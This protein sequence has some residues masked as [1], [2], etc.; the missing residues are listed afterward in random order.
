MMQKSKDHS[1][2]LKILLNEWNP[3]GI[4][5]PPDEYDCLIY[6]LLNLL[7]QK[8]SKIEIVKYLTK[9]FHDHFGIELKEIEAVDFTEKLINWYLD[10]Q[11]KTGKVTKKFK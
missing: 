1:R 4:Y 11:I 9:E 10:N 3:L 7:Y 8:S 2:E 5:V 6:P